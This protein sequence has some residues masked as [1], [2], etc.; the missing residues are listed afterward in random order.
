MSKSNR[1]HFTRILRSQSD[2]NKVKSEGGIS[3]TFLIAGS[4]P[5]SR[6][7][8]EYRWRP[9][10]DS[11]GTYWINSH[12]QRAAAAI[13]PRVMRGYVNVDAWNSTKCLEAQW[14]EEVLEMSAG[15]TQDRNVTLLGVE[16]GRR[17]GTSNRTPDLM[18]SLADAWRVDPMSI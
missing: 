5:L 12:F 18:G 14:T 11:C 17:S 9:D 7:L 1:C 6:V 13:T 15:C 3:R 2:A 16:V 10:R 4:G 8:I